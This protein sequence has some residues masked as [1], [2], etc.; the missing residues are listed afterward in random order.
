M[1]AKADKHRCACVLVWTAKQGKKG[2][3]WLQK[4]GEVKDERYCCTI[5]A[6]N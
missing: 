2:R 1:Q 6:F 3:E 4:G 5:C